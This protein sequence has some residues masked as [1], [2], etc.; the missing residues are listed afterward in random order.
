[1]GRRSLGLKLPPGCKRYLDHTG[2]LRTYYRHTRPPTALPG[3]PWSVEFM[4]AYDAAKVCAG[5]DKP[6]TIGVDRTKPGSLNAALVKYYG[7]DEFLAMTKDVK[8]QNRGCL[9]R[10]RAD[11]GDRPLRELQHRHLQG[12]IN[13]LATPHVQ[14]NALRAIRHFLKFALRHHLIDNDASAGVQKDK[15]PR[16]GGFRMWSESDVETY[17]ARHPIGTKACLALQIMLC[18][19]LRRADAA[20]VGPRH[21]RKTDEHPLGVLADY[22]PQK[23]RRTGG[24]FVTVPIHPDLAAAI[25]AT[26]MIGTET[27]LVTDYGKPFTAKGLGAKMREWCDAAGVP[28]MTDITGKSRNV[29]SHGLRKLCLTRLAECGC[30]VFQIAAISGHK[31]LREVQLYVDAYNR[32]QAAAEAMGKLVEAQNRNAVC[33][34]GKDD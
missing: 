31:D 22:Q 3:L 34:N 27:Y 30:N 20:Q 15:L 14:R 1:M 7:S 16:T 4:Q 18:T 23:G 12:Y 19:S 10:W 17:K 2:V 32:K 33:L 13:K 8:Q 5:R 6:L 24:N 25:T 29:A 9:E 11:R 28:P 26:P 21:V